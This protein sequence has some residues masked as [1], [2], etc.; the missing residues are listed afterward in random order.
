MIKF[1]AENHLYFDEQGYIVPGPSEIIAT[2]YG[3]GL[4]NAP[5]FFVDRAANKGHIAH[6]EIDNFLK[7]GQEGE[8]A[9]FRVWHRWWTFSARFDK[10]ENEKI[11]Y[12]QTPSCAFAGTLDF[13]AN[14]WL[15]DWKTSK[16]ATKAQIEKWTMQLSFYCYAMRQMG[17]VVNEPLKILHI[18]DKFSTIHIKYLGD[19]FVEETMAK[20][21][22]IVAGKAVQQVKPAPVQELQTVSQ[23]DL[24]I[25]EDTI[26]QIETLEK[27]VDNIREKIRVEMETRGILYLQIGKVKMTY[28]AG[29]VRKGLDSKKFKEEQPALFASYLKETQ[30]KPSLR[31]TI[32]GK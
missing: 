25:L 4:E 30:Y 12:A 9:E 15:W 17:Y 29:G 31:I 21:K 8:S 32:N 1:D 3:T 10:Y 7:T 26:F 23:N 14:G 6:A 20:Y 27:V 22:D 11:V 19:K 2:V 5:K 13:Y 24:Q 16:T 28:V 18:T